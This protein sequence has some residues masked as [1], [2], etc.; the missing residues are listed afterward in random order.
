MKFIWTTGLV[1]ALISIIGLFA[2]YA[3]HLH[4]ADSTLLWAVFGLSGA[5]GILSVHLNLKAM[6]SVTWSIPLSL[7]A[8]T[9]IGGGYML[10]YRHYAAGNALNLYFGALVLL[11]TV[12]LIISLWHTVRCRRLDA[13]ILASVA[14]PEVKLSDQRFIDYIAYKNNGGQ[15]PSER[16]MTRDELVEY[17]ATNHPDG[18][19]Q[20]ARFGLQQSRPKW[21]QVL[22]P[23][24]FFKN[25]ADRKAYATKFLAS[26]GVYR[27][28][29]P[30][31]E[32]K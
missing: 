6:P 17:V 12:G 27:E 15:M 11:G 29:Y 32:A 10:A 21:M 25:E 22:Y 13:R 5:L 20:W 7:W 24:F 4:G 30:E 14:T 18:L 26:R 19:E 28:S 23:F 9:A 8:G 16:P 31:F 1:L 3:L 2:G